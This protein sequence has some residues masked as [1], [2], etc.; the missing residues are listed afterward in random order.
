MRKYATTWLLLIS[1]FIAEAHSY[2]GRCATVVQNWIY[3][4]ERPM[5]IQ[6]NIKYAS[7]Q[8]NAIIYFVAMLLYLPNRINRTTVIT[9]IILCIVDAAM[10]FH[11]FKTLYYGSVYLWTIILWLFLYNIKAIRYA[12]ISRRKRHNT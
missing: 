6:W 1:I 3:A 9:F 10:Y 11:N 4:V 2:V 7:D 8:V 12:I 5:E